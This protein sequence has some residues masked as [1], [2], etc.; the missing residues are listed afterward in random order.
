MVRRIIED[1]KPNRKGI[2]I[3]P[4]KEVVMSVNL[5]N[6]KI[7]PVKKIEE[8]VKKDEE[9][10]N[11]EFN[12]NIEKKE[13]IIKKY[14][15]KKAA[16]RQRMQR[17]P[18]IKIKSPI[19]HKST[20]VIFILA[21][22]IG[23]VFWG[24][25][26]FQKSDIN[27]TSKHQLITYKEK[28]FTASKDS[29]DNPINFEI[30]IA[31]DK[32][33]KGITLSESKNVS[34]KAQGSITLYNEFATTPQKLLSGTF[35][36]DNS[37][38]AYKTDA[39]VNIPGYKIDKNKKIVPGQ[40]D[41]NITAFLPGEAYNGNPSDFIINSLKDTKKYNKIYGKLKSPLI[42]G[43]SGLVY[44]PNDEDRV[45]INNIAQ[46]SFKEDLLNQ[47]KALV[48]PGYILY[49]NAI[50]FSYKVADNI[51]SKTPMAEIEMEGSISVV[52]LKEQSLIDNIIK[53]SLTDVKN[54][55][56]KEIKLFGLD[57]LAFNFTNK[58]EFITKEMSAISFSFTGDIDA[59]WY[60]DV[61]LIKS[62]LAGTQKNDAMTIFRQDPGIASALIKVFPPWYKYIPSD[63][64]KINIIVK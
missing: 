60:P 49:P 6:I 20:L 27:I 5:E 44:S 28:Q 50:N 59:T 16:E 38:K 15:K 51:L 22:L 46:S 52:I 37:G 53:I 14:F 9:K 36:S 39:L 42:G 21:T 17:T 55:E 29:I 2:N 62:R 64:S 25:K 13:G 32:K 31:S 1:I 48:P 30:M 10:L 41:V 34:I 26:I 58:E 43:A 57:K 63:T 33:I 24:G 23:G 19:L 35:I 40:A 56:I 11:D 8:E 12:I 61:E 18:Q 7:Q 54:E 4:I 47:V 45:N 3:P